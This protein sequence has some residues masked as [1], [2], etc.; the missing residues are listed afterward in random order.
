MSGHP[1]G[2]FA[3]L[4]TVLRAASATAFAAL[5]GCAAMSDDTASRFVV[6]PGKFG[7]YSCAQLSGTLT[8]TRARITQ[9]EKLNARAAQEPI[10]AILGGA[11]Y[12][13]EYL[14]SR[15]DERELLARLQEKNCE[16]DS[17]HPSDRSVY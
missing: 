12:R 14:T 1:R 17:T 8:G 13:T 3:A 7:L 6:S 16:A 2:R 15:G 5:A 11:S 10:G 4:P 9:L